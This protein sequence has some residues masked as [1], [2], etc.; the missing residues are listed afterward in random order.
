MSSFLLH[1]TY[2][3]KRLA[4]RFQYV[5]PVKSW[6]KDFVLCNDFIHHLQGK[7]FCNCP[8]S[9]MKF[10]SF[11]GSCLMLSLSM[12]VHLGL[13]WCIQLAKFVVRTDSLFNVV[14]YTLQKKSILYPTLYFFS[15]LK[16]FMF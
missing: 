3:K 10:T 15:V 6:P 8:K 5:N 12:T 9:C 16:W 13:K 7:V 11:L 4:V 14:T 1:L 2:L